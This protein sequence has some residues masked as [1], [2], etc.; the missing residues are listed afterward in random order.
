M[1]ITSN[2]IWWH[3]V[4]GREHLNS[5][6]L[7]I[8]HS[9]FTWS[10]ATSYHAYSS[11]LSD[12]VLYLIH[13]VAGT[14]GLLIVRYAIFFSMLMLTLHYAV[15]RGVANNPITWLIILTGFGI[16]LPSSTVK[17]ELFS[18]HFM[19]LVIWLYY[20]L[21]ASGEGAWRLAYFFPLIILV[22][23]NI[24]GAFFLSA[25]FFAATIFGELLNVRFNPDQAMPSRLRKHYFFAMLLCVPAILVN[26][27]G[28]DLPLTII[29]LI[30]NEGTQYYNQ[31]SAYQP[32]YIFNDPPYYL[33]DYMIIAMILFVVLLWQKMKLRQTDWVVILSFVAYCLLYVQI[34]RT[35]YYLTPVFMFAAL[36]MLSVKDRS[37]L[38]P[39]NKVGK[40]VI[41]I[42]CGVTIGFL[43]WRVA[44]HQKSMINDPIRRIE[45]M[46]VIAHKY[47]Q[48][49]A[50][51]IVSN[52]QGNRVGNIYGDG[53]YLIYRLWPE[54]KVLIDPRYFPFKAWIGDYFQFSQEGKDIP[55]FLNSMKA[56][57]WLINYN[58]I[59][60]FEWFSKSK[61]WALAFFGPVGSVFVPI[62]EFDGTTTIS[63]EVANLTSA[64]QL[65]VVLNAVLIQN[66]IALAKE[67][68]RIVEANVDD[69][70]TYKLPFLQEI[71]TTIL[72]M[73]ALKNS[74]YEKAADSFSNAGFIS[75]GSFQS[76]KIYRYLASKAW[77]DEDY[78][79]ARE[80][81][82]D[83]YMV[84]QDKSFLD[85]Y[86]IVL[87]DWHARHQSVD[88]KI[89]DDQVE[90][91][92]FADLMLKNRKLIKSEQ[93]LT[94]VE[95]MKD[96]KYVGDA[97]LFQQSVLLENED[98]NAVA[99]GVS[100][101]H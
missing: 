100:L 35:T 78:L 91:E 66:N 17:P 5:G 50:D 13:E 22:W 51:F 83:A 62:E 79:H 67:I 4:L 9:V 33:L 61:D 89:P 77:R 81:S 27:Y 86:N 93:I 54:K 47:P 42:I 3:M 58:K 1:P 53:G 97:D 92:M 68:H 76:A 46:Q 31:I 52:L 88:A 69:N 64:A 101:Q 26:P 16:C 73:E 28:I 40:Y 2:D 34:V 8:D 25:L 80:W 60:L 94:T 84:M 55:K 65:A 74:E 21:R 59:N 41:V 43:L 14:S 12:I 7:I 19:L 20:Y 95:M 6:S 82:I 44:I 36:D 72:G 48:A 96:G 11:W 71:D 24:H 38:W 90:W 15:K 49:E 10:P 56:D 23:A 57:Y 45:A 85:I 99:S 29:E 32:T 98:N 39:E 30:F 75:Y 87:T 70:L 18:L 63:S 37:S